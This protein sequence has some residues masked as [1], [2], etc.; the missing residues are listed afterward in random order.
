[1]RKRSYV[2]DRFDRKTRLRNGGDR[3]IASATGTLDAHV[4]LFHTELL[5][6][7]GG[8]LRGH[9]T[10]ERRA[11]TTSLEP[12]RSGRRP[13]KDVAL[14]V[15]DRNVRVVKADL[16]VRHAA[17]HVSLDLAF[18]RNFCHFSQIDANRSIPSASF[19]NDLCF[20][21]SMLKR[22]NVRRRN[23][24]DRRATSPINDP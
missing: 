10:R 5:R 21:Y 11:F 14:N 3:H 15:G 20:E 1:M 19:A 2:F 4:D 9:L 16:D 24:T 13:A 7:V 22:Q 12:A 6:F 8:L 18:L 23:Q 17:G